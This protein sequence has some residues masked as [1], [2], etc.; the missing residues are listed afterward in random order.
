[1]IGFA[2][3]GTLFTALHQY[4]CFGVGAAIITFKMYGTIPREGVAEWTP[5]CVH[6]LLYC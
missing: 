6:I 4:P 5:F 1:M 3:A 2:H